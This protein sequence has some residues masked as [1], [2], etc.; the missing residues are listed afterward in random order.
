MRL[1]TAIMTTKSANN[2]RSSPIAVAMM[3]ALI[4]AAA[5]AEPPVEPAAPSSLPDNAAAVGTAAADAAAADSGQVS[6]A[7]PDTTLVRITSSF[8]VKYAS[9]VLRQVAKLMRG[10][11]VRKDAEAVARSIHLLPADQS[12]HWDFSVTY[13]RQSYPLQIRARLDDFGM[14]D[15][16]FYCAPSVAGAVRGAVDGYLNSRGL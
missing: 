11:F 8:D 3:T 12:R 15:L 10:G 16:D 7:A 13:K 2:S 6:A 5:W 14:L 9:A 4:C 1:K